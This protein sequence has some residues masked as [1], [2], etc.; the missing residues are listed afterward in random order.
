MSRDFV[1]FRSQLLDQELGSGPRR[2]ANVV[3]IGRHSQ[4]EV[5]PVLDVSR[6]APPPSPVTVGD[7]ELV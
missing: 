4:T 2:P 1:V 6:V 5:R 7:K 3:S